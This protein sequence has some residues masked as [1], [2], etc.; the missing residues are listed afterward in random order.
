ML[1]P[2]EACVSCSLFCSLASLRL[3]CP[4]SQKLTLSVP[5]HWVVLHCS[6]S[7][8]ASLSWHF[9][10]IPL[11]CCVLVGLCSSFCLPGLV[12]SPSLFPCLR[13]PLSLCSF[14]T[15]P[16]WLSKDFSLLPPLSLSQIF[17]TTLMTGPAQMRG[18]CRQH[19]FGL[20]TWMK[21]SDF[22]LHAPLLTLIASAAT[23]GETGRA[24]TR[25]TPPSP[26]RAKG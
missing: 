13:G 19:F 7:T 14:L 17:T 4:Y 26:S 9:R 25:H 1:C 3:S 20:Y 5:G 18:F 6:P 23:P 10:L 12:L 22:L 21:P 8:P 15:H 11:H 16:P 2:L 24:I